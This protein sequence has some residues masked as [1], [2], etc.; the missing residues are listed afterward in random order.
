MMGH[1]E[2]G[3]GLRAQEVGRQDAAGGCW[4]VQPQATQSA[5]GQRLPRTSPGPH[6]RGVC[7]GRSSVRRGSAC[8]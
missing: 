6:R 4:T 8:T 7:A 2:P 5:L 1:Q 3:A